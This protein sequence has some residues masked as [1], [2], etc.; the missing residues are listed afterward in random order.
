MSAGAAPR[1]VV[2]TGPAASG[3]TTVGVALAAATGLRFLDADDVHTAAS[4][5]KMALGLGLTDA[6]RAPWLAALQREIA[7]ALAGPGAGG[8]EGAGGAG[9]AAD[10]GLALA[11]S[12]LRRAHRTALVPPDAT[13]G[14]V[15][16]VYLRATPELL[17]RRLSRRAGHFA[18]P[19]LLPSQL[20]A[21]EEPRAGEGVLVVDA[22][23][24]PAA[25]VAEIRAALAI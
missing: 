18:G 2:V 13:P 5:A 22:A 16:F 1:V 17:A 10:G 6:E 21:L 9:G 24:P 19:A 7:A 15:R 8:A 4:K 20:A 25:I 23:A 14:D 3:K 11:C 12:A